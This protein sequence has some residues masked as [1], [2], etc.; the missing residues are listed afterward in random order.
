[1]GFHIDSTSACP[2]NII[3]KLPDVSRH[4]TSEDYDIYGFLEV[5]DVCKVIVF[6]KYQ[7]GAE[8]VFCAVFPA[9]SKLLN[10]TGTN[11]PTTRKRAYVG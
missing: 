9:I 2:K 11:K 4:F 6:W 3:L 1:M 8:A 7:F 5:H 10:S